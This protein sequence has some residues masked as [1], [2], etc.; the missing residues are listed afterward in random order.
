[1]RM[2]TPPTALGAILSLALVGCAVASPG[3]IMTASDLTGNTVTQDRDLDG[4]TS[5]EVEGSATLVVT[6]GE[7]FDVLVTADSAVVDH[8]KT[9]VVDGELV[10]SERYVVLGTSPDVTVTVTL[11]R[12]EAVEISGAAHAFIS[13]VTGGELDLILNGSADVT[14]D[15]EVDSLKIDTNG[16][17]E[18]TARGSAAELGVDISGSGDVDAATLASRSARVNI[19]GFG[20][21]TVNAANTLDVRLSGAGDVRYVGSPAITSDL[22]G[23]GEVRPAGD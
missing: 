20:D 10:V 22:G 19:S 15:V 23:L 2:A 11:P 3:R 7:K 5:I 18:V 4:F 1:M 17:G 21:V 6:E 9:T 8:V 12:L 13:D 14:A 16:Y